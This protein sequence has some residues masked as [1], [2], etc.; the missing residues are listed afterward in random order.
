MATGILLSNTL[1]S[2]QIEPFL[3]NIDASYFFTAL[4]SDDIK[5]LSFRFSLAILYLALAHVS[6][7]LSNTYGRSKHYS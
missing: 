5:S 6:G 2:R 4:F 7:Q 1:F 3:N